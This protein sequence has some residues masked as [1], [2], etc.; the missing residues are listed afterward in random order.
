MIGARF[1]NTS[2]P[3]AEHKPPRESVRSA[4]VLVD[5]GQHSQGSFE[6]RTLPLVGLNVY[7][8]RIDA[9]TVHRRPEDITADSVDDFFISTLVEGEVVIEQGDVKFTLPPGELAVMAGGLPYSVKYTKPS[10]R[11]ILQIPKQIY[12]ERIV[13][14][15][16]ADFHARI[17]HHNGLVPVIIS[18]F[19]SMPDELENLSET[20]QY[21]L[22][23]AFLELV[24]SVIRH[25]AK[26][27]EKQ[28][29]AN[30]SA[31][32]RRII[33]YMDDHY[34]DCDLTPERVAEANGISMRYLHRLFQQ[35]GMT[36]CKW[37]WERRL[38]AT[39][40]D[41]LDPAM[42]NMRISE[43]AF[44]RGFNDPAHFSR[45]FRERFGMS[46]SK[47]RHKA[48]AEHSQSSAN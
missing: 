48:S 13:G 32:M 22:A 10:R 31:L 16:E 19:E 37:I 15:E 34:S 21:T 14:R 2:P 5:S 9:I 25:S 3:G 18:M 11:L 42:A 38:K 4:A 23:E 30:Q 12:H 33:N 6:I 28:P 39:R 1:A 27:E 24:G 46:P 17:L 36:V 20:E 35:S 8:L 29:Q 26:V 47:L 43:I 40:E 45:S 44:R 7:D 41:I